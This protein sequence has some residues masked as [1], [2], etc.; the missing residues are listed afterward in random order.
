[1]TDR[2]RQWLELADVAEALDPRLCPLARAVRALLAGAE[3]PFELKRQ[4]GQRTAVT[5]IRIERRDELLR[6][7]AARFFP[8]LPAASQA[9]EI[10][11][12]MHDY[13]TRGWV[14]DRG[15]A[16]CPA[17]RRAHITGALWHVFKLEPRPLGED[18]LRRVLVASSLYS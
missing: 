4:P 12:V 6:E 5:T 11:R 17:R 15:D 16:E 18:R 9:R 3:D 10:A 13:F 8:G 1:M 7:V 14:N 2:A